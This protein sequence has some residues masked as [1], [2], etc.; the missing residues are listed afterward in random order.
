MVVATIAFLMGLFNTH[1]SSPER[2]IFYFA[3]NTINT[4]AIMSIRQS[5]TA[6]PCRAA[7]SV[8]TISPGEPRIKEYLASGDEPIV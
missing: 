7:L 8:S 4:V 5:D 3:T 1:S 2:F 6:I